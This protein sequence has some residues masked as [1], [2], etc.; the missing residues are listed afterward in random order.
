MEKENNIY[1]QL[2][3][4]MLKM[5]VSFGIERACDQ[6][7]TEGIILHCTKGHKIESK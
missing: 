2:L 5:S 4:T 1:S 7:W 3:E 6:K